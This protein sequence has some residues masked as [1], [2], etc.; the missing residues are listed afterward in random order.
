MLDM[1]M[2]V[3]PA[4]TSA[5]LIN[6]LSKFCEA[7]GNGDTRDFAENFARYTVKYSGVFN[8]DGSFN[9]GSAFRFGH[10]HSRTVNVAGIARYADTVDHG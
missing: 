6:P 7:I 1:G 5:R 8:D 4:H 10:F 9:D 2:A 3:D